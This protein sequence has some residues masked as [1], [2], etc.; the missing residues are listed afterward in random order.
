MDGGDDGKDDMDQG[1]ADGGDMDYDM[2]HGKDGGKMKMPKEHLDAFHGQLAYTMVATM[3][4]AHYAIEIFKWHH[5]DDYNTDAWKNAQGGTNYYLY[6][7][8]IGYYGGL[9]IWSI[10]SVTQLLSNFGIMSDINMMAWG[11]AGMIGGLL[12]LVGNIIGIYAYEQ[13]YTVE[14]DASSAYSANAATYRTTVESDM[15]MDIALETAHAFELY[16][17]HKNWMWAQYSNL[18]DEK[19]VAL[20]MKKME[21]NEAKKEEM[22]M[23][24]SDDEDDM[25][26]EMDDGM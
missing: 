26:D 23:M 21:E 16:V 18:D 20:V 2:D 12:M 3:S 13:L 6:N 14:N 22:G 24:E 10:L 5:L 4:A 9:A 1:K 11:Y 15:L 25:E 7:R 8:Q 17:E 19:K